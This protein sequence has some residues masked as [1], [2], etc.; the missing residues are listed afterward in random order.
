M[1]RRS[2]LGTV[3][4]ATLL[5][6]MSFA[7]PEHS[8]HRISVQLYTVRDAMK[9]DY[10]NTLAKVAA[11][12]YREVEM[13]GYFN[14][15]PKLDHP[16]NDVKAMLDHHGLK[17]TSGHVSYE[18]LGDRWSQVLDGCKTLGHEYVVNPSIPEGMR[19]S[20][21]GW[22]QAA[23]TFNRAGEASKK[24][25]VQFGYH[26]HWMEFQKVEGQ[27]PYEILL[28]ECDPKL[29]KMEMDLCWAT[30]AGAD[31]VAYF[32]KNPGRFPL[33]HVKDLKKI[34]ANGNEVGQNN[35]TGDTLKSDL[36]DV[37]SGA[38]DW[39]RIFAHADQGGI[40]IFIV[41]NDWPVSAFDSITVSYKYLK[42][43]RF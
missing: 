26:N 1:D 3:T 43:L 34:P 4:A 9:Q 33:V 7:L 12:G 38:I 29:V 31:P 39:K 41:E 22:K 37:G 19:K 35:V 13:A 8:A 11:I 21:D 17:A 42:N 2:F 15:L 28:K 20:L 25:G 18:V 30:A 10:D 14:D 40:K 5:S 36:T 16:V 24:V 32:Q 27:L 23:A 6:R